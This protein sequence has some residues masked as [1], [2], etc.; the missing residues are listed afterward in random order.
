[1]S[2]VDQVISKYIIMPVRQDYSGS[3]DI[4][5]LQA[6]NGKAIAMSV[7]GDLEDKVVIYCHGNGENAVSSDWLW[8]RLCKSGITV[9]TPDYEGCGMSSGV[10]S[11]HGTYSAAHAA[12]DW[13]VTEVRKSPKDI[14]VLGYS[15]GSG[16]ALELASAKELSGII[17]QAP[18]QSGRKMVELYLK[19]K[20][21]LMGVLSSL[22]IPY[23]LFNGV[24]PSDAYAKSV[25]CPALVFHGTDDETVPY[26]QGERIYEELASEKKKMV[27]VKGGGHCTFQEVLGLENYLK[28]LAEFIRSV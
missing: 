10:C 4:R 14:V 1:M 13:L 19:E 26:A 17:L 24:F 25:K 28:Q 21:P 27:S 20:T 23:S 9:V 7:V 11:E 15:L 16:V 6:V 12:Y 2:I 8:R 18:F 3:G 22:P 5:M